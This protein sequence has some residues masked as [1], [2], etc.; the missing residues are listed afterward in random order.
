M[1]ELDLEFRRLL[2]HSN[3]E[4]ITSND[5]DK[6]EGLVA[7]R[8]T[9]EQ[10]FRGVFGQLNINRADLKKELDE[11]NNQ[12]DRFI[13]TKMPN[14]YQTHSV[15]RE[16]HKSRELASVSFAFNKPK[17]KFKHRISKQ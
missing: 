13:K 3:V 8:F 4:T 17:K 14:F 10:I 12:I 6:Y 5:L 2:L 9:L 1:L 15:W 11:V 16:Q 7:H